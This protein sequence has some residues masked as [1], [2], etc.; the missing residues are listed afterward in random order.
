VER[1]S[2]V[3]VQGIP[4]KTR[5]WL[6]PINQ[7]KP[8]ENRRHR[9]ARGAVAIQWAVWIAASR[10]PSN[11]EEFDISLSQLICHDSP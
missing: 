3:F 7:W 5:V 6:E 11:D 10:S 1:R 2:G 9:E 4:E 8:K